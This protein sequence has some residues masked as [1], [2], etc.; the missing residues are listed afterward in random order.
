M[1]GI[2]DSGAGGLAALRELRRINP[3]MDILFLQDRKNAP[4]GTK[5][6][7]EIL[8]LAENNIKRLRAAGA[9]RVLIA[10]CTASTVY[11]RLQRELKEISV[12]IIEPTAE[13]AAGLTRSRK[14]A[15]IATRHTVRCESFSRAIKAKDSAI[16][17]TEI[18]AQELVEIAERISAGL[19]MTDGDEDY[20]SS[21]L[22]RIRATDA[23]TLV[24]GCTHFSHL[25]NK[26]KEKIKNITT[27]D[28]AK[29]GAHIIA[30]SRGRGLGA[31]VFL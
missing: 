2:F 12:P 21:L 29:T 1:T 14:I 18:E 7:E 10:C 4:Y 22:T 31:T 5:T 16:R 11:R 28:A 15:V 9:S 17:V 26:F 6:E 3:S 27:V 19:K 8:A 20:F 24:L 23:D 25:E 30:E 13:L